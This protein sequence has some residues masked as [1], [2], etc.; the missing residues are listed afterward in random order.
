MGHHLS[1]DIV[2]VKQFQAKNKDAQKEVKEA[3]RKASMVEA[4]EKKVREDTKEEIN[5]LQ[6]LIGD[7]FVEVERQ[8]TIV[9]A[10][11]TKKFNAEKRLSK[12]ERDLKEK[13]MEAKKKSIEKY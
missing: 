8:K 13:V 7:V 6:A 2:H 12:W 3:R 10:E 9:A 11:S 5:K 4:I 1:Y